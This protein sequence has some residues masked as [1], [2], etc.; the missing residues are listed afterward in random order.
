MTDHNLIFGIEGRFFS[1]YG[2]HIDYLGSKD[3]Y[4]IKRKYIENRMI[5]DGR[6]NGHHIT[7]INHLE[8]ASFLIPEIDE[9]GNEIKP[10]RRQR[11]RKLKKTRMNIYHRIMKEYGLACFW[12]KPVDLGMGRCTDGNAVS[13]FRVIHW[14]FG[15]TIRSTLGLPR[16]NFHV[17]VGFTPYDVHLYKG[18]ASL[19]CLQR[20]EYCSREQLQK[21]I[22]V[23]EYYIDDKAFIRAL[24]WVCKQNRYHEEK[25]Y[26]D[27]VCSK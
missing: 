19:I 8:I 13:Y 16:S 1:L 23:A 25:K 3:D 10:C 9:D 22:K 14:P 4:V 11:G 24:Y 21:L 17:T 7:V 15:Q 20:D 5:R 6:E 2:L 18:P 12:K 27:E 26:L